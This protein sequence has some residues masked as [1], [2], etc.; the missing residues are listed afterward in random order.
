M[1]SGFIGGG[2]DNRAMGWRDT[3]HPEG[4]LAVKTEVSGLVRVPFRTG[5]VILSGSSVPLLKEDIYRFNSDGTGSGI[6]VAVTQGTAGTCHQAK[7]SFAFAGR[8]LGL[9][10]L[11][12]Y[13]SS[14]AP[15][16]FTV[17][18]DGVSYAVNNQLP[19]TNNGLSEVAY[20][21]GEHCEV[22]D[23]NLSDGVHLCEI[24]VPGA[25]D[26]VNRV[27]LLGY[28]IESRTGATPPRR[29]LSWCN[30]QALTTTAVSADYTHHAELLTE[31]DVCGI[32]KISYYN[33]SGGAVTVTGENYYTTTASTLFIKSIP[34]GETWEYDFGDVVAYDHASGSGKRAFRHK[35]SSNS[36]VVAQVLGG[37]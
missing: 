27:T 12:G 17:C 29:R 23:D 4:V 1:M 3:D 16:D 15:R 13:V 24:I 20:I 35:A 7:I 6:S 32:R 36:A 14:G 19:Q 18:I 34:A 31:N 25:T 28:A 21:I 26:Q 33:S 11:R 9:R 22:I 37:M 10:W 30:P 2:S 8:A 5:Q